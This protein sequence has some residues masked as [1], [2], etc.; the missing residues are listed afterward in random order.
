MQVFGQVLGKNLPISFGFGCSKRCRKPASF[1]QFLY[2]K[3]ERK[4][5]SVTSNLVVGFVA[6]DDR[7][8]FQVRCSRCDAV[9]AEATAGEAGLFLGKALDV[10]IGEAVATG[11]QCPDEVAETVELEN[12]PLLV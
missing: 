7:V 11:H 9:L 2:I 10:L 12:L 5:I 3:G 6:K 4:M 1:V 8:L